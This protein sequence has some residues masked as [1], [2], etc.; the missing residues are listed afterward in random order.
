MVY[1][2]AKPP[3]INFNLFG[4]QFECLMRR[5]SASDGSTVSFIVC[6]HSDD[7]DSFDVIENVVDKTMLNIDSSGARSCKVTD[8][9]L[10][11]RW[12]LVGIFGQDLEE[13]LRFGLKPRS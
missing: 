2:Q 8:E 4:S 6:P 9:L 5:S 7:L 13:L 12:C 11:G 3:F 1:I 10:I